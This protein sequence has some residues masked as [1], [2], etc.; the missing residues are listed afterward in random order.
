MVIDI[1]DSLLRQ[2]EVRV[3]LFLIFGVCV[4]IHFFK[5]FFSSFTFFLCVSDNNDNLSILIA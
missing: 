3:Q 1:I 5:L 2:T 4:I